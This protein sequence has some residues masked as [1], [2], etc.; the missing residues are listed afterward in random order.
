[1]IRSSVLIA[2]SLFAAF[3]AFADHSDLPMNKSE[4]EGGQMQA[5]TNVNQ[6]DDWEM[7]LKVT[8]PATLLSKRTFPVDT[9]QEYELSGKFKSTGNHKGK[10]YFGL[11]CYDKDQKR[12]R[13]ENVYN[14]PGT[15]T[16]LAA[17]CKK[18]DTVIKVKDASKWQQNKLACIAFNID[19]SGQFKD[20]PNRNLST[21]NITKIEKKGDLWEITLK[22]PCNVA[23]T[24]G[25]K[26]RE[27][28]I[29]GSY[30]YCAARGI[31]MSG[32]WQE[33]KAKVRGIL[34]S[35]YSAGQFW[36]GTKYVKVLILANHK[37]DKDSVMLI[38]DV[39]FEIED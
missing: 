34:P 30:M 15:E 3:N 31:L 24:A 5:V 25:T 2:A 19:D 6:G 35:G 20:L 1:M 9:Y 28:R 13:P 17:D 27:H 33:F 8:G 10:L 11:A 4:W 16:V 12:I 23:F 39:E 37:G 21:H 14:I 32:A 18:G 26:V 36:P 29:A 38:D 7:C 22:N